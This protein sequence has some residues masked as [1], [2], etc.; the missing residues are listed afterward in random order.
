MFTELGYF[1]LFAASFLAATIIP[2]SSEVVLS[3][4][5]VAG[6]DPYLSLTVATLG[7]WLGGLS[8][9]LIGWIGKWDWIEKY[10]RIKASQ[11]EKIHAKIKGKEGWIA[12]FCWLPGIGDPLAVALGLIKARPLPTAI[13]MLIGKASR[14]AVWGYLTIRVMNQLS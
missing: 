2:F 10:L 8:S 14:Y 12:F 1:A 9:Y 6:F 3:G 5:L 13:W 4:M 11:I 7:N